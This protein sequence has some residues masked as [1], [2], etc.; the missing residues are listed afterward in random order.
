MSEG[1]RSRLLHHLLRGLLLAGF[2]MLILHLVRSGDLGLYIA[3]RMAGYVKLSAL[4]L[5]AAAVYQLYAALQ[6]WLG[7]RGAGSAYDCGCGHDHAPS[8]S[9]WKNALLYGLFVFPL[10]LG[11]LLPDT[12][13]GSTLAAKKGVS[14]AGAHNVER[15]AQPAA[16]PQPTAAP[17]VPEQDIAAPQDPLDAKFPADVYTETYA[18]HAK[19]LYL[20]EQAIAVP[21]QQFIE[22]L[23]TLDLYRQH[24]VGKT[25][26]VSG[27]VYREPAMPKD[28]LAVS[29]FAMNCCSADSLPYGIML[30]ADEAGSYDADSW[31]E[32]S[33]RLGLDE[34]GG[35]EIMILEAT[36]IAPIA[37]P[38]SPYVYPD[39]EF[40]FEP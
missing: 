16:T 6:L 37:A 8:A 17:E 14:F 40:G 20:Q 15:A 2:A 21:E 36:R 30:R 27:F 1:S 25:V 34:Y 7:R 22:T 24:F 39:Y 28:W 23:T 26:V 18:A 12:I 5:Y 10:A 35:N 9:L 3:P 33:G 13:M 32:V 31:I 38:E 4:G 11:F 19:K 29:R